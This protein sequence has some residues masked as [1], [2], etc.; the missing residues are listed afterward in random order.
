MPKQLSKMFYTNDAAYLEKLQSSYD[1]IRAE[2]S[3][4]SIY[5]AKKLYPK[6]TLAFNTPLPVSASMAHAVSLSDLFAVMCFCPTFPAKISFQINDKHY[7]DGLSIFPAQYFNRRT[8]D[9]IDREK[10]HVLMA[11]RLPKIDLGRT[12]EKWLTLENLPDTLLSQIQHDTGFWTKHEL[13]G[14]IIVSAA[15]LEGPELLGGAN[16]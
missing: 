13:H 12:I 3:E 6:F 1:A 5:L 14:E 10:N 2:F 16:R 11:I 4:D 15:T 9:L 8:I 7:P